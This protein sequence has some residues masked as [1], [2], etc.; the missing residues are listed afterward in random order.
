MKAVVTQILRNHLLL[1]IYLA[2][3]SL[4]LFGIV[5]NSGFKYVNYLSLYFTSFLAFYFLFFKVSRTLKFS[6]N[7]FS[8]R[9]K[10]RNLVHINYL[11]GFSIFAVVLHLIYLKG[12]PAIDGLYAFKLSEVVFIRRAITEDVPSWINYL[13]SWN[14]RAIM[15][16]VL[17]LLFIRK[18]KR[19]YWLFFFVAVLYSFAL[20]QKSMILFVLIPVGFLSIYQRKWLYSLKLVI[21]S[22]V[23]IVG[24]SYIQNVSLRGG[25]NDIKLEYEKDPTFNTALEKILYGLKKRIVLVPGKT[26]VAWFEHIPSDKPFLNGNGYSFVSKITGG[27]YHN[28]ARELYPYV[29]VE[30]AKHG[31]VGSVNVASFMRGYSN[32]GASGLI[33][34][35]L[36]LAFTFVCIG[37]IFAKNLFF[38]LAF[39]SFPVVFLSS[40]SLL[41]ICLSGGWVLTIALFLLYKDLFVLD[42]SEEL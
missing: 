10:I 14:I 2:V 18:D 36:V 23:V 15:P 41:T 28:Y 26:V 32:F 5:A 8:I 17:T 21:T 42:K 16:I 19:M 3:F 40:T 37:S 33:L 20:M 30:N 27:T 13:T 4:L 22:L 24:L 11:I 12:I 35:A 39:N 1:V 29:Y 38:N 25:I 7:A 34:S 6:F 9:E 31:L